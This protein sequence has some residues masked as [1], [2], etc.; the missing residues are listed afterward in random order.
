MDKSIKVKVIILI[1]AL[2]V[3]VVSIIGII[4]TTINNSIE[5]RIIS[6]VKDYLKEYTFNSFDISEI[7]SIDITNTKMEELED[8]KQ[9]SVYGNI[10]I[11]DNYNKFYSASFKGTY[12]IV[13]KDGKE[14]YYSNQIKSVTNTIVNYP[15]GLPINSKTYQTEQERARDA[16]EEFITNP[17]DLGDLIGPGSG[18]TNSVIDLNLVNVSN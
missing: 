17:I 18:T 3:L 10:R 9:F 6:D 14:I 4:I 15:N 1:V 8:K 2:I 7:T 5:N 13:D 16:I 12:D 11:K